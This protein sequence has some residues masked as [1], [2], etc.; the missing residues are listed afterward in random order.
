MHAT[1][2]SA[3]QGASLALEDAIVLA[4]HL[5][6]ATDHE[7]AFAAYERD[8]RPRAEEVVKYARAVN[9]NKRVTKSRLGIALRDAMLPRFLRSASSDTR[10]D[11]LYNHVV[12]W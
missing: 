10:N 1:S 6:D 2:P 5:R 7:Q 3:G 4:R 9:R 12:R 8:R 11:H